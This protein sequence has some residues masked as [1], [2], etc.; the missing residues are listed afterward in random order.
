MQMHDLITPAVVVDHDRLIDN[1]ESMSRKATANNVSLR[2]HIKTHKCLEIANLQKSHGASGITVA[3]V[4]EAVDFAEGGFNDIT[5]A[6]PIVLDKLPVV[7]SLSKRISLN[8]LVD[9]PR[10]VES[11]QSYAE[12]ENVTFNVLLKVDC[13]YHRCGV[14]PESP[15]SVRL[16]DSISN[17]ANLNFAGILTHGGHSYRAKSQDEIRRIAIEEQEVMVKFAKALG[18]ERSDLKPDIVSI[19]ST[20]TMMLAQ[21]IME[22]ITEIRP[23][24]YVFFDYT[25]VAL[26]VCKPTDCALS[27]ISSVRS[28][29]DER[30]I[31][32]AGATALSLDPGPVHIEP[33]CGF[34]K[35]VTDYWMG[36]LDSSTII[37]LSQEHGKVMLTEDTV[38]RTL[39]PGDR[40]RI[41]P[42]HS[43]LT[44][45]LSDDFY[46]ASGED[47]IDVWPV[48]RRR[49]SA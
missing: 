19:G 31:T 8:V 4:G 42:N 38:L 18:Q 13:N 22:G 23:G 40:I 30:I 16:A 6:A 2:P 28:V 7:S 36:E 47:V 48:M 24:S 14:S 45:N 11:L 12:V 49:F 26:G 27:V 34:G 17:A 5:L 41:I 32:D 46:V 35:V 1:I 37:S 39:L 33:D 29:F 3:T 20:P 15:S 9:H 43:C 25:Q 44:A 10:T 21:E